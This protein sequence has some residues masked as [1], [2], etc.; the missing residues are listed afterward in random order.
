MSL[1][2]SHSQDSGDVVVDYVCRDRADPSSAIRCEKQACAPPTPNGGAAGVGSLTRG[3][4][5]D[6]Y[7]D[8]ARLV[9]QWGKKGWQKLH[10]STPGSPRVTRAGWLGSSWRQPASHRGEPRIWGVAL[11]ASTEAPRAVTC[12]GTMPQAWLTAAWPKLTRGSRADVAT[13]FPWV[14][15]PRLAPATLKADRRAKPGSNDTK[16]ERIRATCYV[17]KTAQLCI[18]Q[19][20]TLTLS[21]RMLIRIIDISSINIMVYG[22]NRSFFDCK[23]PRKCSIL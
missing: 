12:V 7:A 18:M 17:G 6:P 9:D 15:D 23:K 20:I 1:F 21:E 19:V 13:L 8:R 10:G 4:L 2:R 22:E 16:G 5:A 11:R 14:P 3:N